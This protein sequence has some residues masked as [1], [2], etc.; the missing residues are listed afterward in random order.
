MNAAKKS[1]VI[2]SWRELRPED[3]AVPVKREG[4]KKI[5]DSHH[6]LAKYFAMGYG[7]GEAAELAGYSIARASILRGD[8]AFSQLVEEYRERI[9]GKQ[10]ESVDEYYAAANR[11]RTKSMR[12]IE[13]KLDG[14]D[15]V[16]EVPFR[17]LAL[18]H[19]DVADRTGYPK[20]TVAVN[21]NVDFAA[22]L[23]QAIAR[24]NKAKIVNPSGAGA[25]TPLAV[26]LGEQVEDRPPAPL[27]I[28]H[29]EKV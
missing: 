23:D 3:A 19:S 10:L 6:L 2:T 9:T 22:R 26:G 17:D 20:R 12:M 18:I 1:P 27:V 5:R 8:P 14:I 24:S 16:D 11:V 13:E 21:V 4:I 25:V 29:G 28:E 15:N 7:T